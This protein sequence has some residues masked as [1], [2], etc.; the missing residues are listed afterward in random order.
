MRAGFA[1]YRNMLIDAADNRASF[2]AG[3]RLPMP[4][5][6]LGGARTEARGRG[7]EPL[8][9]LRLLGDNVQGGAVPDCGHFIPEEQPEVLAQHLLRFFAAGH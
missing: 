5:L 7:E 4:V 8:E 3:F 2:E 1:Y 9:S 6:A